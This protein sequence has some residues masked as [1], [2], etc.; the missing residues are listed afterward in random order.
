MSSPWNPCITAKQTRITMS[1]KHMKKNTWSQ[2]HAQPSKFI[3]LKKS[4]KML[5]K[6]C[7]YQ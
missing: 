2:N 1:K 4:A 7:K 3:P 6:H 5:L